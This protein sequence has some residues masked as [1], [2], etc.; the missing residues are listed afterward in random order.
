MSIKIT[1]DEK[2]RLKVFEKNFGYKFKKKELLV[3]GL[4]HKSYANEKRMG[5]RAHNER[6]E[7]LG[8]AV[9]ELSISHLLMETYP[10]RSEGD[11]SK[12]RAAIVNEK[13]LARMARQLGVG[14]FLRLGRG[15]E[16]TGGKDKDSLLS[17][18]YEALLGAVYLDRGFKKAMVLV[19]KHYKR[20][21]DDVEEEAAWRDY[22]TE[23]QEFIQRKYGVVP[24]YRLVRE[25][26]ADHAKTFEIEIHV[27]GEV[28]GIGSG[29]SKKSAEQ[30]AAEQAFVKF[31]GAAS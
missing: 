31:A 26:G 7:F 1:R 9:L 10:E 22:K 30:A 15:E 11:L 3:N 2:K 8:D 28:L 25:F 16:Q 5:A 14:D 17:D 27:R 24:R 21:L 13:H 18:A 29:Q 23:L 4:T 12:L 6:L 19:E 20:V